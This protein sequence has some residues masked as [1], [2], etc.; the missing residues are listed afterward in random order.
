MRG[1][2]RAKVG[3]VPLLVI[4]K[5]DVEWG[6]GFCISAL[7]GEGIEGLKEEI[8]RRLRLVRVYMKP[9]G[10]EADR[11]RPLVVKEGSTVKDVWEKLRLEGEMEYALVWGSSAKFPGQKV[12]ANHAL[13]DGDILTIA[14]R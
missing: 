12:G 13:R 6:G 14:M 3:G 2:E 11:N 8:Y 1:L 7:T 4:N 5:C 9:R 10:G